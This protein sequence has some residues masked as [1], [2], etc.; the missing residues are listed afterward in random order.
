MA[1]GYVVDITTSTTASSTTFPDGFRVTSISNLD[2][3]NNISISFDGTIGTTGNPEA[4]L[5]PTN[6]T[7]EFQNV[8]N[9]VVTD[10]IYWDASAGTP[11]L[12]VAGY[13]V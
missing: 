8:G 10:I 6:D 9:D 3:T 1:K 5:T 7:I 11:I 12:R 13:I 2:G 4:T